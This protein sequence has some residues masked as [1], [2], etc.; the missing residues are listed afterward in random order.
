VLNPLGVP[1]RMNVGQIFET[2]LGWAAR[3]G[4]KIGTRS[5]PGAKP[6]NPE[7]ASRRACCDKL[8]D[9]YGEHYH[10]EID[11]QVRRSSSWPRT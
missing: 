2:H 4:R 1:S 11:S 3:L 10:A 6:I 8:K 7:A 9:I 5:M